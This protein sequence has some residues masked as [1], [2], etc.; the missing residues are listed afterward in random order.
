VVN[1]ATYI[2]V[3]F[4]LTKRKIL[5]II[6]SRKVNWIGRISRRS[7]LLTNV[8]EGKIEGRIEVTGLRGRKLKQLNWMILR[9]REDTGN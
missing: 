6:K 8:T 3:R 1:P 4:F 7:C 2:T 5:K 9:K